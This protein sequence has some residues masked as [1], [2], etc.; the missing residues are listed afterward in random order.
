MHIKLFLKE[1]SISIYVFY[2]SN[3]S[4]G[5]ALIAYMIVNC[6]INCVTVVAILNGVPNSFLA[7][8]ISTTYVLH[9]FL[10]FIII[11]IL[12]VGL[13]GKLYKPVKRIIHLSLFDRKLAKFSRTKMKIHNY[14]MA[15]NTKKKYGI[16]YGSIG[17]ISMSS[18]AKVNCLLYTLKF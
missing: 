1:I 5:K 13:N 12:V 8:F 17:L 3:S 6:P 4:F 7:L 9:Q 10:C 14:I 11:H 15:F 18:F 2:V 16:T